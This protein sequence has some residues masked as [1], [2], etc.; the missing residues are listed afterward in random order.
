M[1][2]IENSNSP[3]SEAGVV[4]NSKLTQKNT[5]G[6]EFPEGLIDPGGAGVAAIKSTREPS[7]EG[8]ATFS[9][10]TPMM[11]P[12][13]IHQMQQLGLPDWA[14]GLAIEIAR[15]ADKDLFEAVSEL[16]LALLAAE[17]E[18]STALELTERRLFDVLELERGWAFAQ[19]LARGDIPAGAGAVFSRDGAHKRT[20]CLLAGTLLLS[21]RRCMEET[22][23]AESVRRLTDLCFV[24]SDADVDVGFSLTSEQK[25]AV[26]LATSRGLS[27]ITGGPGTGK[28]SIVLALLLA[29]RAGGIDLRRVVLAAP[30]G[31]A[32][33]RLSSSISGRLGTSI[34]AS[35]LHRLLAYSPSQ[36]A[37][38]RGSDSPLSAEVVVVDESSMVDLELFDC[39][40]SALNRGD[41]P[42]RLVL[43]GDADQLPSVS[44]G[45][46]FRDLVKSAPEKCVV[47]LTKSFR[48]NESDP[49]GRA[50]YLA[51][52]AIVKGNLFETISGALEFRGVEHVLPERRGELLRAWFLRVRPGAEFSKMPYDNLESPEELHRLE[53]GFRQLEARRMLAMTRGGRTGVHAL[54]DLILR[55][56]SQV[57][58]G[59]ARTSTFL[60]PGTPLMVQRNEYE[61]ELFNGDLGVLLWVAER[62]QVVF[63][64]RDGGEKPFVSFDLELLRE[65]TEVAWAT[66]VHKAQGSEFDEVALFLPEEETPLRN[67]ANLYTAL[68][69]AKKSAIVVGSDAALSATLRNTEERTTGLGER[70]GQT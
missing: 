41:H 19:T 46:V 37:F 47:Q 49:S 36:R 68:T 40:F 69:R 35:T 29:L 10:S 13:L 33:D 24:A 3:Q 51:S 31:R 43:L 55:E 26:K 53:A 30:T 64:H 61:L 59:K 23:I 67:R 22:R 45:A 48:M 2:P 58:A 21:Q 70:L 56:L 25:A 27:I 7:S 4:T 16:I 66:T 50:I 34:K 6:G 11:T 60:P 8:H 15:W 9:F 44:P 42:T 17:H 63:R 1:D 57:S 14:G 5:N 39:L 62:P 38:Q 65:N 18:G 54:N 20:P 32:A 52:Q 12:K 28:T